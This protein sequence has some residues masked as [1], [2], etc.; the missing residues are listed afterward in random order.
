MHWLMH[1]QPLFGNKRTMKDINSYILLYCSAA[2]LASGFCVCVRACVDPVRDS[3]CVYTNP[4]S[5]Q[6][7]WKVLL[8]TWLLLGQDKDV[9]YTHKHSHAHTYTNAALQT[10]SV[11][12]IYMCV[13][14]CSA[15]KRDLPLPDFWVLCIDNHVNTKSSFYYDFIY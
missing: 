12:D 4:I 8:E 5:P 11:L 7:E 9:S 1:N 15:M 14:V 2:I 3:E 6:W 13:C 10:Q